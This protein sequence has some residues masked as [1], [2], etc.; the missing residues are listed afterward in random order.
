MYNKYEVGSSDRFDQKVYPNVL[1]ELEAIHKSTQRMSGDN[2]SDIVISFL[3]DHC[4]KIEWIAKN[5]KVAKFIT[6]R[7]LATPH[8]ESLFESCRGNQSFLNGFED[9]IKRQL[10]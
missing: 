10:Q 9:C 2:K 1:S 6:S 7:S 3:K 5:P 4:I 8:I